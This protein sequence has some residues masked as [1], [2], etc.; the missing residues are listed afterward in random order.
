MKQLQNRSPLASQ[1]PVLGIHNLHW[2][3]EGN[4]RTND[5]RYTF[6]Q[7]TVPVHHRHICDAQHVINLLRNTS[8]FPVKGSFVHKH[9]TMFATASVVASLRE[10]IMT[11]IYEGV[12]Q[13][14]CRSKD[15]SGVFRS[16]SCSIR[17]EM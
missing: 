2:L 3:R 6:S 16:R 10:P 12:D 4:A 15:V 5:G 9:F 8:S 17:N 7:T 1:Q 13:Y 11:E 14:E